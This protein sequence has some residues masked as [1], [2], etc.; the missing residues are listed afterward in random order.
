M[1]SL[2]AV[3]ERQ[4]VSND[5][6]QNQVFQTESRQPFSLSSAKLRELIKGMG[7]SLHTPRSF[8]DEQVLDILNKEVA[9]FRKDILASGMMDATLATPIYLTLMIA[10]LLV[11]DD[12]TL[13]IGSIPTILHFLKSPF[14]LEGKKSPPCI[15]RIREMLVR[16]MSEESSLIKIINEI[17]DHNND[18]IPKRARQMITAALNIPFDSVITPA[19]KKKV[20]ITTILS[21]PYQVETNDCQAIWPQI[22]FDWFRPEYTL[23]DYKDLV[24]L[25]CVRR[26]FKD[27]IVELS[28]PP[29]LA[30]NTLRVPVS[31]DRTGLVYTEKFPDVSQTAIWQSLP[32]Q[33]AFNQMCLPADN[34]ELNL[35]VLN[36]LFQA[37]SGNGQEKIHVTPLEIIAAYAKVA[38]NGDIALEAELLELG[39]YGF[40]AL[41]NPPVQRALTSSVMYAS[42]YT[43]GPSTLNWFVDCVRNTF[44]K[45]AAELDPPTKGLLDYAWS[46]FSSPYSAEVERMIQLVAQKTREITTIQYEQRQVWDGKGD[47]GQN[48]PYMVNKDTLPHELGKRTGTQEGFKEIVQQ[49]IADAEAQVRT[50][51]NERKR[52]QEIALA[53][54]Q[55]MNGYVQT[56]AFIKTACDDFSS[57][58]GDPAVHPAVSQNVP[59]RFSVTPVGRSDS[60]VYLGEGPNAEAVTNIKGSEGISQVVQWWMEEVADIDNMTL[61][62]EINPITFNGTIFASWFKHSFNWWIFSE[63]LRKLKEMMND[64][65]CSWQDALNTLVIEPGNTVADSPAS[66]PK[67][68]LD[69]LQK[70]LNDAV[71]FSGEVFEAIPTEDSVGLPQ[72][73]YQDYLGRLKKTVAAS[74]N[75]NLLNGT[76]DQKIDEHQELTIFQLSHMIMKDLNNTFNPGGNP[77]VKEVIDGFVSL[78]VI[79][80][81]SKDHYSTIADTAIH[82][83]NANWVATKYSVTWPRNT[84]FCFFQDPATK[85]LT[86]GM[87]T[88]DNQGLIPLPLTT[89]IEAFRVNLRTVPEPIRV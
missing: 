78:V 20:L 86:I 26:M 58:Y 35:A 25:C 36:L 18:E 87:I 17:D 23:K 3:Q 5:V 27:K 61:N 72:M 9:A 33:A 37:A 62:P 40:A 12:G 69:G 46:F 77:V 60:W 24:L 21:V 59:W 30:C 32:I 76:W 13:N 43:Y 1:S 29:Y 6:L 15:E 56:P 28:F 80:N 83:A 19:H 88:D 67:K 41:R 75:L 45:A 39:C 65:N 22:S 64:Q 53:I 8:K 52:F 14:F 81:L 68:L 74:I 42:Q 50:D 51:D 66:D 84:D 85:Q 47:F 49:G 38:A 7:D 73:T 44:K 31:I 11:N 79:K 82:I 70:V 54:L 10:N 63:G 57:H 34:E 16:F 2:S 48:V 71:T 55:K 89:H 4:F